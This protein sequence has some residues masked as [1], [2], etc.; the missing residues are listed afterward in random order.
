VHIH[1]TTFITVSE[2]VTTPSTYSKRS[3]QLNNDI[4]NHS[5]FFSFWGSATDPVYLGFCLLTIHQWLCPQSSLGACPPAQSSFPYLTTYFQNQGCA[6][7]V[8]YNHAG[9][10]QVSRPS[11]CY[12]QIDRFHSL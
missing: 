5:E 2:T 3:V 1:T 6:A 11:D 7:N 8:H 4:G 9:S 10:I 12:K